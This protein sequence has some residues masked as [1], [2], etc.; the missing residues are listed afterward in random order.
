MSAMD[1]SFLFLLTLL[2]STLISSCTN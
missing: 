1:F 2:F